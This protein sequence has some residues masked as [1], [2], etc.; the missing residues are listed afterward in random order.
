[1]AANAAA[2]AFAVPVCQAFADIPFVE[3]VQEETS[4]H[5]AQQD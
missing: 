3:H 2:A 4:C 1:M 5:A